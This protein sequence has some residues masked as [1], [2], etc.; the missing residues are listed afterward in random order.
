MTMPEAASTV[1]DVAFDVAGTSLPVEHA[2]PLLAAVEARLP[3]LAGEALAGIH[4]LRATATAYGLALIARRAKLVLRLPEARLTDALRLE[5]AE[6]DVGGS[7]LR[8]GGGRARP[9][10]PSATLS[11]QRVASRSGDAVGFEAEVAAALERLDIAARLISGRRREGRAGERTIAGFALTLHGLGAA[12]SLRIQSA[13]LGDE[14]RVGWGV[15]VPAKLI[16][17]ADE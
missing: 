6:L 15:F 16:Q 4:P 13:G 12:D 17:A 11:A 14:R 1:V 7:P 10:A 2:W 5:G 8:I 9:L 3:W